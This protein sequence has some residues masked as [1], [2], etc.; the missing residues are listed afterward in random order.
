VEVGATQAA[1]VN[2]QSN[3]SRSGLRIGHRGEREWCG[4]N[5]RRT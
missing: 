5:I 3:L 2:S 1:Q 4:F